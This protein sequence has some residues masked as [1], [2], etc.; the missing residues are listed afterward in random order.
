MKS[1][2]VSTKM[3]KRERKDSGLNLLRA[4]KAQ[5]S[6]NRVNVSKR[7]TIFGMGRGGVLINVLFFNSLCTSTI[8]KKSFQY[9]SNIKLFEPNA[10][11]YSATLVC[12]PWIFA[13]AL[14]WGSL[15]DFLNSHLWSVLHP[16][17][18]YFYL[19]P[20]IPI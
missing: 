7:M 13:I 3:I 5:P 20:L 1:H 4:L 16:I 8:G 15:V 6:I 19:E 10:R 2:K 11:S 17:P 14:H 18:G 12:C 9:L